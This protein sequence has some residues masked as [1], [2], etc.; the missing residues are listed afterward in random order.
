MTLNRSMSLGLTAIAI[1]AAAGMSLC[2]AEAHGGPAGAASASPRVPAAE[3]AVTLLREGNDRFARGI[4]QGPNRD[5]QRMKSVAAE[6]Q[7]FATILTCSDSRVSPELLFDRG[8]GELFVVRV[9]G[10]VCDTDE[11]GTI[12]YGAG[13]LNTPLIV[14]LGHSKCGAVKAVCAGAEVHGNIPGLVDNII[15]AYEAVRAKNPSLEGDDLVKA[16]VRQNVWQSINDLLSRSSEARELV[17][18]GKA[19]IVGATY[20]LDTGKVEWLGRHPEES[21]LLASADEPAAARGVQ[22][23]AAGQS[24]PAQPSAGKPAPASKAADANPHADPHQR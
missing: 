23:T 15:P 16:V 10:N 1:V 4:P 19:M 6:Q 22:R 9:A 2:L 14:V 21:K 13:H 8:I 18:G 11:A 7:P 24:T 12:E 20:D 5:A 3:L 17:S